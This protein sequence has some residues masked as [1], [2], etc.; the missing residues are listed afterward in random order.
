MSTKSNSSDHLKGKRILVSGGSRGLGQSLCLDFASQGADVAF[1]Y[2][3]D[4]E[5][6]NETLQL[7]NSCGVKGLG[8]KISVADKQAVQIMVKDIIADWGSLD[9]LVN[10]AGVSQSMPLALMEEEDWDSLFDINLKG[11]YLL[12]RAVLKGMVRERQGVI[13]NVG[14]LA[15]TRMIEA[16]VHYCSSKAA[17]KGFTESLAKEL[18]RYNIRVNCIAPGLLEQGVATNL[19][20][21]QLNEYLSQLALGRVG[22]LREVSALARFMISDRNTAMTG[23]T[24][25]ID[26]GF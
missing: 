13:L 1:C 6:A 10:N 16:P 17:I 5:S 15:G 20:A 2:S 12:T 18:G 4:E 21:T 22:K 26:G 14:S 9:V 23:S 25:L 3:S 24:I 19:P 7:I 11:I 8:F